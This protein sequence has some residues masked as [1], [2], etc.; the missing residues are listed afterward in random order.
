M[1]AYVIVQVSVKNPI[2]YEEYKKGVP[3]TLA[4]YGGKFLV[5]GGK[6]ETIEGDWKPERFVLLEFP[7]IERAKEWWASPEYQAIAGIR[8]ANAESQMIMVEGYTPP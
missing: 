4:M 3:G 2:E 1:A 6:V 7:T 5:R 8:F